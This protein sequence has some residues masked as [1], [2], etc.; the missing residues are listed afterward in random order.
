MTTNRPRGAAYRVESWKIQN[1]WIRAS[2]IEVYRNRHCCT[3]CY[4]ECSSV[5]RRTFVS[6]R[7]WEWRAVK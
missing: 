2:L 6:G 3:W 4:G 5:E 7:G 1:R